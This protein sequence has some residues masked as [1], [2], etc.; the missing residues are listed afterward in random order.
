MIINLGIRQNNT[1][2]VGPLRGPITLAYYLYPRLRSLP[3]AIQGCSLFEGI[4]IAFRF[5]TLASPA[6]P[7]R[8]GG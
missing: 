5:L 6:L 3:G 7:E 1:P 4:H 2:L 8:S